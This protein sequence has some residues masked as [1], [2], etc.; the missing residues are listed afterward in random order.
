MRLGVCLDKSIFYGIK[1]SSQTYGLLFFTA[2]YVFMCLFFERE[3]ASYPEVP[4]ETYV[5]TMCEAQG[6]KRRASQSAHHGRPRQE[7]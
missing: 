5:G 3:S 4:E 2:I 1:W 6:E 7:Q